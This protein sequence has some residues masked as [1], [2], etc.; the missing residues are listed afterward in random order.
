[1]K[2]S[3]SAPSPLRVILYISLAFFLAGCQNAGTDQTHPDSSE[4]SSEGQYAVM[5]EVSYSHDQEAVLDFQNRLAIDQTEQY[6]GLDIPQQPLL[7]EPEHLPQALYYDSGIHITYPEDGVKGVYLTAANVGDPEYLDYII[8]YINQTELNAVVIDFKDDWGHIIPANE[9]D[10][11]WVQENTIEQ[12]DYRAVL[13]KLEAHQIYP[14]ARIVAFKDNLLSDQH[15]ELS[16]VQASTGE[17]WADGNGS[18]FINPFLFEVWDYTV[19]VSIEA[20]KMG[21]KDIQFDYVRFPEG[22]YEFGDSLNYTIGDY[23]VYLTDDP[24]AQGYERT[25]AINDF[26]RYAREQLSPYG[27]DVSADIFGYTT[28]AGNTFDVRG[29]GQNIAQMAEHVDVIS[30]MIYPSHWSPGFFGLS[31]P[32][33]YPFEV[34]NAYMF[35]E[36]DVTSTSQN[37]VRTRPWLQDFTYAYGH[38]LYKEYTAADVQAQINALYYHGVHEYLL[39][40]AGGYYTEGVDYAPD[41]DQAVDEKGEYLPGMEPETSY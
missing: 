31:A 11:P 6:E 15:P 26:L 8:N 21:F 30:A 36:K 14:I 12:V 16:F 1:M 37:D 17:L 22:F 24:D 13:E 34:V 29:I 18:Q 20:A 38:S 27:V 33:L 3:T 28:V 23:A 32:D 9:S 4:D 10:H 19:Q 2:F 41:I 39:W 7:Q 5:P 25:A 40:N 35:E